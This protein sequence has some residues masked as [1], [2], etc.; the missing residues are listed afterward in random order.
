MRRNYPISSQE[1]NDIIVN[2]YGDLCYLLGYADSDN[3]RYSGLFEAIEESGLAYLATASGIPHLGNNDS[4][5]Q[6]GLSY[7]NTT[8]T[9]VHFLKFDYLYRKDRG[10][11]RGN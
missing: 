3:N 2:A 6:L 4:K 9:I 11:I 10:Y 1:L 5:Y 7:V 8:D